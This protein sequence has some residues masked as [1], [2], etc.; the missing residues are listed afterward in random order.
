[1]GKGEEEKERR[2]STVL[3]VDNYNLAQIEASLR[4]QPNLP[5]NP[6]SSSLLDADQHRIIQQEQMY[7]LLRFVGCRVELHKRRRFGD[8]VSTGSVGEELL[9]TFDAFPEGGEL[10][11]V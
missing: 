7:G 10:G 5:S 3:E 4:H 1:V 6:R 8:D 11:F 2:T 9:R